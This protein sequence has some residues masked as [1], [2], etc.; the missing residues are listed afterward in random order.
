MFLTQEELGRGPLYP[1]YCIPFE[2]ECGWV[3][4]ATVS[5]PV[6]PKGFL[7]W[8]MPKGILCLCV[9][10]W[11]MLS[12]P[13]KRSALPALCPKPAQALP[14]FVADARGLGGPAHPANPT[15]GWPQQPASAAGLELLLPE[16]GGRRNC[17]RVWG[18][19]LLQEARDRREVL[20]PEKHAVPWWKL[21]L[22]CTGSQ[23]YSGCVT[24]LRSSCPHPNG[25][26]SALRSWGASVRLH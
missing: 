13:G 17:S 9:T 10:C 26:S 21:L 3:V 14:A 7:S 15:A 22:G 23:V 11:R 12:T 8:Q 6:F 24:Q 18:S 16:L 5:H 2:P 20:G 4:M 1:I 25:W 19:P